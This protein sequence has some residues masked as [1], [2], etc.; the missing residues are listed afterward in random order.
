MK[1][2]LIGHLTG[3]AVITLSL[4][5][6]GLAP[7]QAAP[8]DPTTTVTIVTFND[9]HGH[10]DANTY[11]W[12]ATLE[13][14]ALADPGNTVVVSAGDNIGASTFASYMQ[15]D[16]PAIELLN[17]LAAAVNFQASSVGNHEFDRGWDDLTGRVAGLIDGWVYLGA[18]VYAKGTQTPMLPEY[19][20]QTLASG[21]TVAT[22]GAVT[23]ETSSTVASSM[24]VNLEFGDPVSAVNRVA[25]QLKD[26]DPDNGEADIVIGDYHEGAFNTTS[27]EAAMADSAIFTRIMNE[28]SADVDVLV[29]GHTHQL[30]GW[31]DSG[32]PVPGRTVVQA[33]HYAADI[34]LIKL[35]VDNV[36]QTVTGATVTTVP[37]MAAPTTA[38]EEAAIL[39]IGNIAEVKDGVT[40]ALAEAEVLGQ[41][42]VGRI[43]A[44]ITTAFAG[45]EWVDG[46][47]TDAGAGVRDDRENESTLGRLVADAFL[48]SAN[49]PSG[50]VG[51]ADL[52]I[53]N[54][55]GGTRAELLYD[56]ATDGLVTY[57]DANNV[58][59]FGN[60]LWTIDLT[61][62]QLKQFAEEQWQ[63]DDTGQRP[64]TPFLNTAFSSNVT[65]TVNSDDPLAAPGGHVTSMWVNGQPVD[66]EQTYTIITVSFIAEGEDNYHVMT[67]GTNVRTT[68]LLDRDAW[69][70]YLSGQS[71]VG[72]EATALAAAI[73]PNFARQSVV[74]TD[75]SPAPTVD[76][77][78]LIE[79]ITV[80]AGQSLQVTLS[81]L[82]LTSLGSPANTSVSLSLT[83]APTLVTG[84]AAQA[85]A[86]SAPA[87]VIDLGTVPV[88]PPVA[89]QSSGTAAIKVTIP[90]AV[91]PGRYLWQAV[92]QPSNTTVL[93]VV[94]VT[95]VQPVNPTT[96]PVNPTTPPVEPVPAPP[97]G[98]SALPG[99][100]AE[101][102]RGL[103]GWAV[104]ALALG[105]A[106]LIGRRLAWR[107]GGN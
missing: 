85:H 20:L 32:Q 101:T 81:R 17:Q 35:T 31:T 105:A 78:G 7:T 59:P 64:T 39:A 44:D 77:A 57:E 24:T 95:G 21:L 26:G 104:V 69:I 55:G 62:A 82:N 51:G 70:D 36:N 18:N 14:A 40:Q 16:Q 3:L 29:N 48:A 102:P 45:G 10:L 1:R 27:L 99:A 90:A 50:S 96:P 33:D 91:A 49:D 67:E 13:Q 4:T 37:T 46:V 63:V 87:G 25:A 52:G 75:V 84:A 86:V 72:P 88:S 5:G 2:R 28:T 79:S 94:D 80:P 53:Q 42:P 47:Y 76:A 11:L 74:L 30:Y 41:Q 107:R 54:N 73:S 56:A 38:A 100:G 19:H 98:P 6:I 8:G 12:A 83:P 93:L 43:T 65:Y 103:V 22:I 68:G 60:E 89:G 92:A 9:F 58:L 66:P 97:T 106:G 34:G 15:A 61:G 23:Q 71:D